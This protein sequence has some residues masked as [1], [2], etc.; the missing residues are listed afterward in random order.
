MVLCE[1]MVVVIMVIPGFVEMVNVI[2][3]RELSVEVMVCWL[4]RQ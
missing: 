1:V 2:V 3:V 4:R